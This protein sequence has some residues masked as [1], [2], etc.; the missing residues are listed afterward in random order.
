MCECH[1]SQLQF[2]YR[3]VRFS[4]RLKL[5]VS[6]RF[7]HKKKRGKNQYIDIKETDRLS[8]VILISKV[9]S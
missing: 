3:S 7:L 4:G 8:T 2:N 6:A 5:F 1:C 9:L